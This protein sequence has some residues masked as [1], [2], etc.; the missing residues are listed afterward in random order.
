MSNAKF[1]AL[2]LSIEA[3]ISS[4]TKTENTLLFR[5]NPRPRRKVR[6]ATALPDRGSQIAQ[7]PQ[8]SG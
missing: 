1:P 7:E 5:T 6:L 2:V 8:A 4:P 3:S